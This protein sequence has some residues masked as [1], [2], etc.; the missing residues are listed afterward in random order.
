MSWLFCRFRYCK[1]TRL[2]QLGRERTRQLVILQIQILQANELAQLGRERTRQL[3]ILQ[4]ELRQFDK[5]AQLGR[6]RTRQLVSA[7]S[8]DCQA[9]RVGLRAGG[10]GHRLTGCWLRSLSVVRFWSWPSW[11]GIG[12]VNWLS[13]QTQSIRQVL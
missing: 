13:R 2:A 11:G 12:P 3:V 1:R 4:M 9:P 8:K 5:L 7:Q 6:E 10:S